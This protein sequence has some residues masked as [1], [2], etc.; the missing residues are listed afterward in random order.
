[1][2]L[3]IGVAALALLLG[4]GGWRVTH[5]DDDSERIVGIIGEPSPGGPSL[6]FDGTTPAIAG[7]QPVGQLEGG[8]APDPLTA[9]GRYLEAE[10]AGDTAGSFLVLSTTDRGRYTSPA[11]WEQAHRALPP[12]VGYR[13]GAVTDGGDRTTVAVD[14]DLAAGLDVVVGDIPAH[15]T[16]TWATV[17]EGDAWFVSLDD[18]AL[19]AVYPSDATAADATAAWVAARQRCSIASEFETVVGSPALAEPLCGSQKA[20]VIGSPEPLEPTDGAPV[21]AAFGDRATDW[22]RVVSVRGPTSLRAV[23]APVGD[24]WIV[25]GVLPPPP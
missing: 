24:D 13:L 8:G 14:L 11:K 16:A 18:S 1:V 9:V 20:A 2:L 25:V 21:V 7:A 4:F 17:R 5:R 12:I 22:A 23:L 6:P 10:V 19:E 3:D 15:A